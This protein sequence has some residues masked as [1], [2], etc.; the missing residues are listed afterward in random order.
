VQRDIPRILEAFLSFLQVVEDYRAE[1]RGMGPTLDGNSE[2][3][4]EE[5]E[6]EERGC[7]KAEIERAGKY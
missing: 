7:M 5:K 4:V 1:V 2:I 6:R 3:G